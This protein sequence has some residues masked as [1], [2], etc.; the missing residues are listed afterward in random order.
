MFPD[1]YVCGGIPAPS[2]MS[3]R[4]IHS[5]IRGWLSGFWTSYFL[6]CEVVSLTP[7]PQPGGPGYPSSPGPYTLTC[8]AWVAL[9]VATL[10]PA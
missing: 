5:S 8:P 3:T 6:R 1:V 7:N 10:P 9:S 2:L 4:S